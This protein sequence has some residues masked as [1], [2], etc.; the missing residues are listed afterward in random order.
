MEGMVGIVGMVGIDGSGGTDGS[1]GMVGFVVGSPGIVGSGVVPGIVGKFGMFGSCSRLRA[2]SH[3]PI[4]SV[5]RTATSAR[6]KAVKKKP[7]AEAI[8]AASFDY[9]SIC[10]RAG[11]IGAS[12]DAFTTTLDFHQ[13]SVIIFD[14]YRSI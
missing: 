3:R 12:T 13:Y 9:E 5:A 6:T 11:L 10:E 7:R 14:H 1:V 2:A 8:D 4:R